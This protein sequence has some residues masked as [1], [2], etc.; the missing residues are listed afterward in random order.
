MS[1]YNESYL[2]DAMCNLGEMLDYAVNDCGYDLEEFYEWF[3]FSEIGAM[4]AVGNPKYVTGMSGVEL[5]RAVIYRIKCEREN[6]ELSRNL[7]RSKEYWTG[8]SLAYYQHHKD[9]AFSDLVRHGLTADFVISKY[10][11]HEADITKF[12]EVADA[13]IEAQ[14]DNRESTLRRLR[15]YYQLTQ[16]MLSEKSGVSLRMIQLYEQGQNDISKAQ[17][18]VVMALAHA[19]NCRVE[20]IVKKDVS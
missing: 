6:R 9:I 17:A 8:W 10:I 19:L 12:V 15:K 14:I 3:A 1:A 2:D 11:L 13:V 5:A 20:D 4:F 18:N 7:N 16:K